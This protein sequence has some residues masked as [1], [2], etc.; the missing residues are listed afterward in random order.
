MH[1]PLEP[2]DTSRKNHDRDKVLRD[3]GKII[4]E[5]PVLDKAPTEANEYERR[6]NI[7]AEIARRRTANRQLNIALILGIIAFAIG[8][9]ASFILD[10]NTVN[11]SGLIAVF[12]GILGFSFLSKHVRGPYGLNIGF[13]GWLALGLN[14]FGALNG[15]GALGSSYSPW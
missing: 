14:F 8:F 5:Q 6:A 4:A 1:Y 3:A 11:F 2:R 7:E 15:F 10:I 9:H 12:F 13:K